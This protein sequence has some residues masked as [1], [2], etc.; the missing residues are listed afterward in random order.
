MVG[1]KNFFINHLKGLASRVMANP[2]R[3]YHKKKAKNCYRD[4]CSIICNN[5]TDG[6]ILH[7]LDLKFDTPTINT[8]FYSADDFVFFVSNIREFSKCDVFKVN[9]STYSYPVGGIKLDGRVVKIGFV[10]YSNF[11]EAKSKWIER[12][13]RVDFENMIILWEGKGIGEK[14]LNSL[15]ALK[16]KKMVISNVDDTLS[17]KFPFYRGSS[18]YENWFPG[19]ILEYKNIFGRKR[20]LDDFDYISLINDGVKF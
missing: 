11:E 15:N 1:Y 4:K 9:D 10:H 12:F 3:L 8:L 16:E 20:F 2:R 13:T 19:K 6:V 18:L 7:D 5:C 14:E 17:N